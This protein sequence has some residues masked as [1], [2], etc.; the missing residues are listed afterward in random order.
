MSYKSNNLYNRGLFLQR[1]NFFKNKI[2]IEKELKSKYIDNSSLN[3]IFTK[4]KDKSYYDMPPATSNC[5]TKDLHQ[6][7]LSFFKKI[8][9]GDKKE[10]PPKY[11]AKGKKR[12]FNF[13]DFQYKLEGNTLI[14]MPK[15]LNW[16]FEVPDYITS[17]KSIEIEPHKDFFVMSLIYKIREQKIEVEAQFNRVA[18][19]DLGLNNLIAVYCLDSSKGYLINGKGLKSKNIYYNY[20]ISKE[21]S[22]L[23][24][25]F[26][27]YSSKELTR[28]WTKRSNV[29]KDFI[30]KTTSKIVEICIENE[31]DTFIIGHNK[32][33]KQ[34]C[35]IKNFTQIPIFSLIPI[36]KY[37]LNEK[38]IALVEVNENYTSG[39][40]FLDFEEP[41]KKNYD[42]ERR[43]CR[44]LFVSNNG[45][46]LNSDINSAGQIAKKAKCFKEDKIKQLTEHT[47]YILSP[48]KIVI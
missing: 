19:G 42:I 35:K 4:S 17:I 12:K 46:N 36:L 8:K 18:S 27:V 24:K 14:I 3:K 26:N 30:H 7:W 40:S 37:K 28:L 34:Y 13:Q 32:N 48:V 29:M 20:K 33:Q 5:V 23:K 43:T 6:A 45:V 22:R 1:Q 16:Q 21:Q 39:M 44:G 47:K 38:N 25:D 2:T 9:N 11:N 31:I 10:R 15:V 41:N